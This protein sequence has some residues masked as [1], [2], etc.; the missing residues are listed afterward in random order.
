MKTLT[1]IIITFS[2]MITSTFGSSNPGLEFDLNTN[3]VKSQMAELSLLETLIDHH[4]S[5]NLA[6]VT[7]RYPALFSNF[8]VPKFSPYISSIMNTNQQLNG[9]NGCVVAVG[10]TCCVFI[11]LSLGYYLVSKI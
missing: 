7:Q 9:D 3:E 6:L 10:I 2:L 5:I 4:S 1:S 8:V 11:S